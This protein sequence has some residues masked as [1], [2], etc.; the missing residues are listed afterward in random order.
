V[1][2]NLQTVNWNAIDD[3]I[4]VASHIKESVKRLVPDIEQ[5][6]RAHVVYLFY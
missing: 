2:L 4:F 5:Q 1:A 3:L 6:V